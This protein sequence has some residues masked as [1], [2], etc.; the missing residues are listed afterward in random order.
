MQTSF[1]KA[2]WTGVAPLGF[3]LAMAGC[4]SE[5]VDRSSDRA[6][7]EGTGEL[8]ASLAQIPDD[9]RCVQITTSD[10]Q[11]APTINVDVTPGTSQTIRIGPL[12]A[13]QIWLNGSAHSSAC[14]DINSVNQTWVADNTVTVV[15]NGRVSPVTMTFRR[16][17][18]VDVTVDFEHCDGGFSGDGGTLRCVD[19][20]VDAGVW[21][22]R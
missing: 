22:V 20:G 13:G 18:R 6:F 5:S 9:V 2:L 8:V 19:D 15:E 16:L 10:W 12:F 1:K 7:A 3:A 4:S 14:A 17:G 21:Q 11:H